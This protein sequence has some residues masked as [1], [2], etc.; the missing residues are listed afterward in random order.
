MSEPPAPRCLCIVS[1]HPVRSGE[2][3]DA[4]RTMVDTHEVEV[5]V[6][7]RRR[8]FN[9]TDQQL[10]ERRRQPSVDVRLKLDGFAMVPDPSPSLAGSPSD[11][12]LAG[13]PFD[14]LLAGA[15]LD[16]ADPD[17]PELEGVLQFN[18]QRKGRR[19]RRLALA[20]LVGATLALL[21][22]T[23]VPT[24]KALM[25]STRP[26]APPAAE[27]PSTI[28]M[29]PPLAPTDAS[30]QSHESLRSPEPTPPAVKRT[31]R[32]R[33]KPA[34][35]P[36]MRRTNA[37][38]HAAQIPKAVQRPEVAPSPPPSQ[39]TAG[40]APAAQ[41]ATAAEVAAQSP[42]VAPPPSDGAR[43]PAPAAQAATTAEV[44]APRGQIAPPE[45]APT[46]QAPTATTR[47][48]SR[49]PSASS[50]SDRHVGG[51]GDQFKNLGTVM[52][53]DVIEATADAKRQG[54]DFRTLQNR[55]RRA[56]DSVKQGFVGAAE[57]I[58]E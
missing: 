40:P 52:E 24:M 23:W 21:L 50:P 30:P 14:E 20:L 5:I 43:E 12:V 35:S 15:P 29:S 16:E 22:L 39:G 17:E 44:N 42:E 53:R 38:V 28:A 13:R 32:P 45:A 11:G 46:G 55:L 2:L 58:R 1:G 18:R 56:W 3:L 8:E 25:S 33:A 7:R 27:S 36:P 34:G 47:D 31:G 57:K 10:A 9:A 4:L 6:D 49:A 41:A 37:P 19:R 54:D 51:L 26:G 48:A